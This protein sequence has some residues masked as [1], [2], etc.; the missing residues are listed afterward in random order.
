MSVQGGENA[1]EIFRA[2]RQKSAPWGLKFDDDRSAQ[3]APHLT[4]LTSAER[5][6]WASKSRQ[7]KAVEYLR[8]QPESEPSDERVTDLQR[9][10]THFYTVSDSDDEKELDSID[11]AILDAVKAT[12][13]ADAQPASVYSDSETVDA[14]L[15][16]IKC[17]GCGDFSDGDSTRNQIQCSKCEFFSHGECVSD[18]LGEDGEPQFILA[19]DVD[20]EH[21]KHQLN[22][23][24]Y[25]PPMFQSREIVMLPDPRVEDNWQ[26]ENV[27]WYP[28]RFRKHLLD[29]QNPSHEFE[30]RFLHCIEWPL[31]EG[32]LAPPYP[33]A[34]RDRELVD[35][36]LRVKLTAKQLG[37]IR[38]PCFYSSDP[39]QDHDLVG[40]FDAVLPLLVKLLTTLPGEHPVINSYNKFFEDRPE[41]HRDSEKHISQWLPGG[42]DHPSAELIAL[43]LRPIEKLQHSRPASV[44]NEE[45][46]RRILGVGTTLLQLL[47]IQ[48]ELEE[49]LNLNGDIFVDLVEDEVKAADNAVAEAERAMILALDL[50]VLRHR[51]YWDKHQPPTFESALEKQGSRS[52]LLKSVREFVA[53]RKMTTRTM[54]K[55]NPQQSDRLQ[56]RTLRPRGKDS[57]SK[58]K[59]IA[60][61]IVQSGRGWDIVEMDDS[62]RNE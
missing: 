51:K 17:A 40:I 36:F 20:S 5:L 9:Y 21:G 33:V 61:K 54:L 24:Q 15:N 56:L 37:K 59:V 4:Q 23:T 13:A 41:H 1:Q 46:N 57:R 16:P 12:S 2:E 62:E 31:R 30:F 48:Q 7:A 58:K 50:K 38:I 19:R 32:E 3:E 18:C 44:S 42:P 27:L 22:R 11:N 47:A 53:G 45:W 55:K 26:A 8:N 6:A 25:S 34:K 35:A 29:A 14:L 52:L 10:R 60:G 49:P 39:P 28:A 43:M